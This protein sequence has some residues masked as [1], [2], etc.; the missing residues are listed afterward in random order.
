MLVGEREDSIA[1]DYRFNRE[2]LVKLPAP[3]PEVRLFNNKFT[4]YLNLDVVSVFWRS[5]FIH[6]PS[7]SPPAAHHRYWW[8]SGYFVR[9]LPGLLISSC[10]PG[11]CLPLSSS[12]TGALFTAALNNAVWCTDASLQWKSHIQVLENSNPKQISYTFFLSFLQSSADFALDALADDFTS[13]SGASLPTETTQEVNAQVPF[14]P[15]WT[16]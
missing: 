13:S 15:F 2:E 9:R 12:C 16:L 4:Y 14:E 7:V 11:S 1:P 5:T 3:K 6:F 10:C 8:G